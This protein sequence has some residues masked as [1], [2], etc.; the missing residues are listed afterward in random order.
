[1]SLLTYFFN[2][3]QQR[4]GQQMSKPNQMELMIYDLHFSLRNLI[5]FIVRADPPVTWAADS[6]VK[7]SELPD[8]IRALEV[9]G[10][11]SAALLDIKAFFGSEFVNAGSEP[12]Q[13]LH[14]VVA[15]VVESADG[16]QRTVHLSEIDSGVA[17]TKSV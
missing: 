1:M 10:R 2:Y 4:K 5:N 12:D 15:V 16:I 11:A 6:S 8:Y 17:F 14:K 9:C 13:I 3:E 7:V